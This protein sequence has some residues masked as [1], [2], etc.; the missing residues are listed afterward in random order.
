[1]RPGFLGTAKLNIAIEL[2]SKDVCGQRNR[3]QVLTLVAALTFHYPVLLHA[4]SWR[5]NAPLGNLNLPAT[6]D[7]EVD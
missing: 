5:D 6:M 3:T 4:V 2:R 1:V 7:D